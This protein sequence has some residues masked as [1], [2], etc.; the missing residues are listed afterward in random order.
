MVCGE[1]I[2]TIGKK[3]EDYL[4]AI[5]LLRKRRG[6]VRSVDVA[7]YLNVSKPSVTAMMTALSEAG[8]VE[9]SARA[10]RE[11]ALTPEGERIAEQICEKNRFFRDLLTQAGVDGTTAEQEACE[12][13]HALSNESFCLLR[14][15]LDKAR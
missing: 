12:M 14:E 6:F 4:K 5:L 11:I 15:A 7:R 1:G 10:P 9:K 3:R 2:V 13:E 8:Y